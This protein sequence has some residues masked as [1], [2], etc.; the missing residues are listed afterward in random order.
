MVH[1]CGILSSN[2]EGSNNWGY[3]KPIMDSL[4]FLKVKRTHPFLFIFRNKFVQWSFPI[5]VPLWCSSGKCSPVKGQRY[6]YE[7]FSLHIHRCDGN[8]RPI[9]RQERYSG[10]I[11]L[12]KALNSSLR[13]DWEEM[14]FTQSGWVGTSPCYSLDISTT[15]RKESLL[16]NSS[17]GPYN[18]FTTTTWD[19]HLIFLS[20]GHGI[21]TTR[22][23]FTLTSLN[24]PHS[25]RTAARSRT[26]KNPALLILQTTF[27]TT[28]S[29]FTV[30]G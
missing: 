30:K 12:L 2:H 22:L 16:D 23:T 11:E 5:I 6:S 7:T 21:F 13:L 9:P 25:C 29:T 19:W 18:L 20:L 15:F 1:A 14:D 3:K 10:V 17:E 26:L 27:W 8:L 4:V 24:I 28:V